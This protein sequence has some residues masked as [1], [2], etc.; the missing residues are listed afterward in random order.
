MI[1]RGPLGVGKTTIARMLAKE[2]NA[3]YIS[4]DEILDKHGLD[5]APPEAECI[6]VENFIKADEIIFPEVKQLLE[7]NKPVI[8]DG[9]FYHKK[10]IEH[11]IEN[12]NHPYFVFTLKASLDACIERD[13]N[14]NKTYGEGAAGAVH[15]LVSK[16]DY[17]ILINTEN[18]TVEETL[19]QVIANI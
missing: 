11:I 4:I 7:K 8:F 9:C 3:E 19:R 12:L 10:H 15:Y 17:G 14:R 2:L 6:P 18:K 16:F 1:I 13:K 5:Q